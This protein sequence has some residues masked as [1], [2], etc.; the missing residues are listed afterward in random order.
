MKNMKKQDNHKFKKKNH[1][2]PQTQHPHKKNHKNPAKKKKNILCPF[3]CPFQ[4]QHDIKN[5]S[6]LNG[7]NI[8]LVFFVEVSSISGPRERIEAGK[9]VNANAT[10]ADACKSS[11]RHPSAFKLIYIC[12][13]CYF[14]ACKCNCFINHHPRT[15]CLFGMEKRFFSYSLNERERE[16]VRVSLPCIQSSNIVSLRVAYSHYVSK[17]I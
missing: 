12:F 3:S 14:H 5:F 6:L 1:K 16:R 11:L 7:S 13:C 10:D 2:S 9:E 15:V 4:F 8:L 17:S